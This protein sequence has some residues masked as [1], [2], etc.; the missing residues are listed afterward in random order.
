MACH[1]LCTAIGPSPVLVVNQ[2]FNTLLAFNWWC[3][4]TYMFQSTVTVKG[5]LSFTTHLYLKI[6]QNHVLKTRCNQ[7][8]PALLSISYT[9]LK[10]KAKCVETQNSK[11]AMWSSI[12][13][14]YG[15]CVIFAIELRRWAGNSC[16]HGLIFESSIPIFAVWN[17]IWHFL[18]FY[19]TIYHH[20]ATELQFS[21]PWTFRVLPLA[22][23]ITNSGAISC[24]Y[25]H[26]YQRNPR[27]LANKTDI[28]CL[29][30]MKW[31]LDRVQALFEANRTVPCRT[32]Q[33]GSHCERSSAFAE[34]E[35]KWT[36]AG[37][38]RYPIGALQYIRKWSAMAHFQTSSAWVR[39]AL[40]AFKCPSGAA[41]YGYGMGMARFRRALERTPKSMSFF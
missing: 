2:L 32:F 24:S 13:D 11:F 3:Y 28:Q 14:E 7:E 15:I 33:G 25:M 30:S 4:P 12:G 36:K 38:P 21:N 39:F 35:P 34:S 41:R 23:R 31:N 22:C 37:H 17:P 20:L 1:R 8:K 18:S 10:S 16:W 19:S 29:W 6:A 9:S 27:M 5:Y 40:E 26:Q